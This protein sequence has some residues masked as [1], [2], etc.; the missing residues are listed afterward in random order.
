MVTIDVLKG[1]TILRELADHEL[2]NIAKIAHE[3]TYESGARIFAEGALAQRMFILLE[4]EVELRIWNNHETG[5]FTVDTITNGEIFG[6]SALTEPYS[7][8]AAAWVTKEAKVIAISGDS[9]R[10]LFEKNNHIGYLVMR[11]IASVISWRLK[12]LR[13]KL[14]ESVQ[15]QK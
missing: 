1:V 2:E 9:L 8:T 5:P 13:A 7:L 11:R 4:G 6:W 14:L 3:R 12:N 15:V 10:D